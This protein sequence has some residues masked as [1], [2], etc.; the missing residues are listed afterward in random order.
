MGIDLP[1]YVLFTRTDR[2]PFFTEYF[3]KLNEEEVTRILGATLPLVESR[4]GVYAEEET[5][6]LNGAFEG[7]FHSLANAPPRLSAARSQPGQLSGI[8]E[9]P[10][11]FRKIRAPLVRFLV[12]MGRPSQLNAGPFLRGFYFSGVRPIW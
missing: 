10:R 7:I 3:S 2:I 5:A 1:V 8:Y 9:F 4:R 6:R 11:E 12:E